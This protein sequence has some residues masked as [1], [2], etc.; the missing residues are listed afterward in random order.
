[1]TRMHTWMHM[2]SFFSFFSQRCYMY[3]AEHGLTTYVVVIC[4]P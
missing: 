4:L 3:A 2:P 1:V